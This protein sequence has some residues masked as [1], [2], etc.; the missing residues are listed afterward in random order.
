LSS[1]YVLFPWLIVEHM[2]DEYKGN[3]ELCY[4]HAA[5]A[6]AAAL[7]MLQNLSR[8]D[9]QSLGDI[10]PVVTMTIRRDLVRVWIMHSSHSKGTCVS[11]IG[12]WLPSY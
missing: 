10:P 11:R 5:N 7:R 1:E 12:S 2:K 4:S 3:A 6:G 8:H 9:S